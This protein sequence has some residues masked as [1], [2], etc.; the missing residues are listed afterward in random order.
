MYIRPKNEYQADVQDLQRCC[1]DHSAPVGI[2]EPIE[3]LKQWLERQ[4]AKRTDAAPKQ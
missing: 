3:N 1:A 4:A 2:V